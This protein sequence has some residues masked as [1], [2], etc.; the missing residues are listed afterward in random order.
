MNILAIGA[1]PDDIEYGCGGTL[2]K[3]K[4]EGHKV[5]MMIMTRGEVGGDPEIRSREQRSVAEFIGVDDIIWGDQADTKI[6]VDKEIIN[7][8]DKAIKKSQ[9][10]IV[11]FNYTDDTHQDHR[12]LARCAMSATRHLKRVLMFEVPTSQHFEP[13]IFVDIGDD[14]I[15]RKERLLLLHASQVDKTSIPH[16]EINEGMRACAGFRGYQGRVKYAEGFKAVRYLI[17]WKL[18]F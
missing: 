10:E 12:A 4:Q 17:D 5:C 14:V 1:H 6:P 3:M 7:L 11:L 9:A 8:I 13:D 16:L 15:E 18:S 2:L